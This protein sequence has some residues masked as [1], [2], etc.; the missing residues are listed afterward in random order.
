MSKDVCEL[1]TTL[2][3]IEK[4]LTG[5]NTGCDN[6]LLRR[7]FDRAFSLLM[8]QLQMLSE[9]FHTI[10]TVVVSTSSIFKCLWVEYGGQQGQQLGIEYTSLNLLS[11]Y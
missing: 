7:A 5:K 9:A 8:H 11:T 1:K 3:V 2:G 6:H 4:T 10:D